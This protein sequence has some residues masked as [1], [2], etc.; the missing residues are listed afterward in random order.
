MPGILGSV[1]VGIGD[2]GNACA[3]FAGSSLSFAVTVLTGADPMTTFADSGSHT[4]TSTSVTC[5]DDDTRGRK[6]MRFFLNVNLTP[7]APGIGS[8]DMSPPAPPPSAFD[9]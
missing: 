1:I 3:S 6:L 8:A 7:P 4:R 2:E 9:A 5:P